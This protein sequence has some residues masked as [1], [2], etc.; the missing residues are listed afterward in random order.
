MKIDTFRR[1]FPV[2]IV[3]AGGQP[4]RVI[5]TRG[6]SGGPVLVMLPGTLG[7]AEIF[8]NQIASLGRDVRI[9]SVTYPPVGN[10][11]KLAA[12]LNALFDKLGIEKASVVGSSLGGFLAQ[13]FAA[14]YP[15]RVETLFIGNSLTDPYKVNPSRKPP[16]VLRRLPP[17]DHRRIVL[18]SVESWKEPEPI[19]KT[20][21]DIL[22]HSGRK[23]ISP[24]ALKQRVLATATAKEVPPPVIPQSRT[25]IIECADD[26]LIPPAAQKEMRKKYPRAARYRLSRGG[27][28][29]YITRAERYTRIL[30]RHLP[31]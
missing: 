2:R 17:A 15:K 1:R 3:R 4:W 12:G 13:W 14:R 19:F 21:K 24:A 7:T 5:E 22:L 23:L 10:L 28:Y 20:L 29:P 9:V 27:H 16:A 8:W 25:V 11:M 30:K 26:P 31:R 18:G 6:K